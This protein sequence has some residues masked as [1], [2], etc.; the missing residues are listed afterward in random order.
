MANLCNDLNVCAGHIQ[1]GDLVAFPTETVYGLGANALNEL[2]VRKIFQAKK[3]P[4]TD[5]VIVHVNSVSE[6]LALI[7][8]NDP[9]ILQMYEHLALHYWPGPFTIISKAGSL[10]SPILTANTGFVGI[11]CPN[12]P[13]AQALIR[14]AGVP[15]AAPS[16]N[17]FAHVSPTTAD[18]VMIDF[19]DSE[20]NIKI[21]DGG[22][23]SFGIESTVAKLYRQNGSLCLTVLRK[24]GI[25]E[26][27]L[28]EFLAGRNIIV[29]SK[30]TFTAIETGNEAPGQ[31]IKHYSPN[32]D[33]Y[34]VSK[35]PLTGTLHRLAGL[36]DAVVIDFNGLLSK[37][38]CKARHELSAYGE[39][40]EAINNLYA[41]LR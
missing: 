40:E 31:L 22:K 2:A 9:E 39:I 27:N 14:E 18:H 7:D 21:L 25:S 36:D 38:N 8:E 26:K 33:T 5:P 29:N 12:H 11:R 20:F 3:R 37:I 13:L 1:N 23:C 24:G 35:I 15:I 6:A 4:L 32:I 16:A 10:I 30:Q 28:Q 41:A 19:I 17:L 34:L